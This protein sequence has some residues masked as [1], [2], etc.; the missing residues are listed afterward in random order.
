VVCFVTL[1]KV[2]RLGFRRVVH[3]ALEPYIANNFLEN[4]ATNS[5]GFGVP[6]DVVTALERL[7]DRPLSFPKVW[8]A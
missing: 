3:V 7:G 6:F 8:D 5:A 2:L 1:D 4:D